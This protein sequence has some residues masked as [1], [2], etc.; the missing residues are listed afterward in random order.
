MLA[1]THTQAEIHNVAWP[2][3]PIADLDANC[4]VFREVRY[5]STFIVQLHI[6]YLNLPQI[7]PWAL[8]YFDLQLNTH[9]HLSITC[10]FL[11]SRP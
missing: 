8:K 11:V 2:S 7:F 4:I 3:L 9:G 6:M 5:Y 1:H 10:Y